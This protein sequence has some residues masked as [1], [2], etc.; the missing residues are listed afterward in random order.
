MIKTK[1]QLNVTKERIE[2]FKT[3]I[4]DAEAA[5]PAADVSQRVHQ[6]YVAGLKA[7]L[8][9]MREEVCEYQCLEANDASR[10]RLDSLADLPIGLIQAR[11]YRGVSQSELARKIGVKPQQM[12]RWEAEDNASVSLS[13]L[14]AI[15]SALEVDV[16]GR[17]AGKAL[18]TSVQMQVVD[19]LRVRDVV[20]SAVRANDAQGHFNVVRY[21]QV[22]DLHT[23]D[24]GR[25][26][27]EP[28]EAGVLT[29]TGVPL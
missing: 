6:A 29:I 3:A 1:N 17:L 25:E 27:L 18:R 26:A 24:G 12:Q 8:E 20:S 11:I 15:A 10:V 22:F 9:K 16:A 19:F 28:E 23:R 5:G 13:T 2:Q 14:A 21:G 7:T 4:A